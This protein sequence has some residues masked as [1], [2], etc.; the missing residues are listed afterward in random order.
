M[1][2]WLKGNRILTDEE[3]RS[4]AFHD[5][6]AAFASAHPIISLIVGL[7]VGGIVCWFLITA[8]K[9]DH[10]G[11]PLAFGAIAGTA[12]FFYSSAILGFI[13]AMLI[14]ALLYY[15]LVA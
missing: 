1:A 14:L 5:E 12:G 7:M 13:G 3:A 9:P 10:W 4:E 15:W 2:Y 8:L 11:W 6:N